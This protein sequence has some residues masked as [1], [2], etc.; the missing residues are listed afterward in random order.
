MLEASSS[1]PSLKIT[2]AQNPDSAANRRHKQKQQEK[3]R[4]KKAQLQHQADVQHQLTRQQ[5][6]E[7]S[8]SSQPSRSTSVHRNVVEVDPCSTTSSLSNLVSTRLGPLVNL[9]P[10]NDEDGLSLITPYRL[11]QEEDPA[12]SE[13]PV[14]AAPVVAKQFI[15]EE[16][17]VGKEDFIIHPSASLPVLDPPAAAEETDFELQVAVDENDNLPTSSP[18]RSK[19]KSVAIIPAGSSLATR[20]QAAYSSSS[21][22]HHSAKRRRYEEASGGER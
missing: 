14:L 17:E 11:V 9:V 18:Q 13:A 21:S 22:R 10:T 6:G 8:T 1:P 4:L 20:E 16:V 5:L 7:P 2:R 19:P 3:K 15:P 12:Q